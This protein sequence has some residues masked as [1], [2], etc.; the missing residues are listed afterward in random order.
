[1]T[2]TM[3][4]HGGSLVRVWACGHEP[5]DSWGYHCNES[6]VLLHAAT[7]CTH[8]DHGL[9]DDYPAVVRFVSIYVGGY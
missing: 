7:Q 5:I 9:R 1:M 6:L 2:L 4:K 3:T 8:F